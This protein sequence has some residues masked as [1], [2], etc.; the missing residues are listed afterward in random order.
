MGDRTPPPV[1][2]KVA[3]YLA[4][5]PTAAPAAIQPTTVFIGDS[6]TVGA[7]ATGEAKGWAYVAARSLDWF[8]YISADAASGY[9]TPGKRGLTLDELI[10]TAKPEIAPT[11]VVIASGYND[12]ASDEVL[13]SDA[14]NADLDAAKAKWKTAKLIV[15][16]PWAP[17]GT[18][19]ENQSTA[20]DL[21]KTAAA[22]RKAVFID[23]IS[24]GWFK[25]P[26]MIGN[27]KIHPNDAGHRILGENAAA[28]IK[29]ALKL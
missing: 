7:G 9:I 14:I 27:D 5:P 1:S 11:Y 21:L 18:V 23:P 6:Y 17:N 3:S 15:I 2:E 24:E 22:E 20:R 25:T 28:A 26:G 19:N 10:T 8:P 12:S 13:L 29:A 4:H 16:G